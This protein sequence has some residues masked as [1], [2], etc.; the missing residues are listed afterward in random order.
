MKNYDYLKRYIRNNFTNIDESQVED[1]AKSVSLIIKQVV[2]ENDDICQG[3]E[4]TELH[5]VYNYVLE[6][7]VDIF[8]SMCKEIK[9]KANK[10]VA[11]KYT[12][13]TEGLYSSESMNKKILDTNDV[14]FTHITN[15]NNLKGIIAEAKSIEE[16]Y[17]ER[18][19]ENKLRITLYDN[20]LRTFLSHQQL[21]S[22]YDKKMYE[23]TVDRWM[24]LPNNPLADRMNIEKTTF[25]SLEKAQE[26]FDNIVS[27]YMNTQEYAGWVKNSMDAYC[28]V[29]ERAVKCIWY[30]GPEGANITFHI[31]LTELL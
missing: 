19:S 8:I 28:S 6:Y 25:S 9:E 14:E 1:M 5:K 17:K 24:K 30:E 3:I 21:K 13:I 22:L 7:G 16:M 18:I 11:H 20:E 15:D 31:R 2:I 12:L 26:E 27:I 10:C 4:S 23:I 29:G